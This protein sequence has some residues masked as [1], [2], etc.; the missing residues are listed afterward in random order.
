ML[1]LVSIAAVAGKAFG[2]YDRIMRISFMLWICRKQV[3]GWCEDAAVEK[4]RDIW[5]EL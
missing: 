4:G 1:G 2:V 5:R 3:H